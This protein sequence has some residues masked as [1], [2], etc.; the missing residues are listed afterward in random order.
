MTENTKAKSPDQEEKTGDEII[1]LNVAFKF[2]EEWITELAANPEEEH[3]KPAKAFAEYYGVK[4]KSPA[5]LMFVAFTGGIAK[6]IEL[7][8]MLEET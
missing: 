4:E 7:V 6:G 2:W 8:T 5:A 1:A 3:K